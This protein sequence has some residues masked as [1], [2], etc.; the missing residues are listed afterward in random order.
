MKLTCGIDRFGFGRK[1]TGG[2]FLID[3]QPEGMIVEDERRKVKVKGETCIPT[4]TYK[5]GLRT[6]GGMHADYAKRFAAFHKGMIWI[7]NV[8]GFEWVY[9]HC[10]NLEKHSDGCPLI[11][12][13]MIMTPDYEFEGRESEKAYRRIAPRITDA[14]LGDGAEIVISERQAA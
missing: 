1:S 8:P 11:N 6:E 9:L 12:T 5:L 2:L 13:S 4:G 3:N 10:G 14:I 7:L